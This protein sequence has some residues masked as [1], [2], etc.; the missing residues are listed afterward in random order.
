MHG[1]GALCGAAALRP[2]LHVRGLHAG[3]AGQGAAGRGWRSVTV[4]DV[5]RAGHGMECVREGAEAVVLF[6]T[7]PFV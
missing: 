7:S 5:L 2:P 3:V 4:P 6:S 1:A